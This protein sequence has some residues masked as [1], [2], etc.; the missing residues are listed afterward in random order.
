MK[1]VAI[2]AAAAL[3]V[4]GVALA[5]GGQAGSQPAA[6]KGAMAGKRAAHHKKQHGLMRGRLANAELHVV[7][8][9]GKDVTVRIDRGVI[10]SASSN[11]LVLHELDGN[12]VTVPLSP[13]TRVMKMHKRAAIGDLRA[14]DVGVA[15]RRDG[16]A[17]RVVRSPGHPPRKH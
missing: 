8:R 14:G 1:V 2:A 11:S 16:Q 6:G 7:T 13:S 3:T 15:I 10:R 4:G 12:D 17:A 9:A 5:N